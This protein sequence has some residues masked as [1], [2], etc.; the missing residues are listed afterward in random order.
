M[1]KYRNK[2]ERIFEND[3]IQAPAVSAIYAVKWL[4]EL[5]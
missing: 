3:P 4:I 1:K 2:M 5:V